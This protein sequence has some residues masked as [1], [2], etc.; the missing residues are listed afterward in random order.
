MLSVDV[1][2]SPAASRDTLDMPV[3]VVTICANHVRDAL[4]S[5]QKLD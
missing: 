2:D 1:M 3:D 4:D 5:L